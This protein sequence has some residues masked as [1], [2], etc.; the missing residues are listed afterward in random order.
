LGGV[1][2]NF[3]FWG[4]II[5]NCSGFVFIKKRVVVGE[6]QGERRIKWNC[7]VKM[8]EESCRVTEK[9]KWAKAGK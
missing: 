5:T 8:A 6:G 1:K 2:I 7:L 4:L 3:V 9:A